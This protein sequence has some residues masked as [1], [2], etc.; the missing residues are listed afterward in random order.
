[1]ALVKGALR[2][3]K[4]LRT[5]SAGDAVSLD[6]LMEA[7]GWSEVSAKTYLR[8]NKLS[9]FLLPLTGRSLKVMMEGNELSERYFDEVFTQT[10]PPKLSLAVGDK[11]TGE[12]DSYTLVEP[13]GAG[14]IGHVWSARAD[15]R[16]GES[17][18]AVKV[19]LPRA[20]LLADSKIVDVRERF[21]R[22]ARNGNSLAHPRLV[23]YLDLGELHGNP[24]LVMERGRQ[25]VGEMLKNDGA[26]PIEEVAAI[27]DA[28][29][30]GLGHLHSKMCPHRDVKPD[31]ILA[32]NDGFKL[33]DLGIVK[34]SDFDPR[35]TTGGTLTR[36]SMQLG[37]W[38]YMAPEQQQNPHEAVPA[39]D[40]YALGVTWIEMLTG[41]LPSPHA[42]GA[43]QYSRP[44]DDDEVCALLRRMVEYLPS[45]RPT[46][47]EIKEEVERLSS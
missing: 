8:K 24:F 3:F 34:W 27:V 37:S 14:A 44:C 10:A 6:G 7:S 1:M 33:A 12:K 39:S 2:C 31:N 41:E 45:D 15:S 19:M 40:V 11:L 43:A 9:P 26:I 29:V 21:R 22:E 23:S 30:D 36:E 16:A 42:V 5:K 38:F 28:V 46:L 13:I 47:V 35:F 4:W 17:L 25:S 32:C 18:V 20:D